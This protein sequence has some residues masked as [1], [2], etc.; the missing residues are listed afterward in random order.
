MFETFNAIGQENLTAPDVVLGIVSFF[1]VSI[2]GIIIGLIYGVLTAFFTKYT[3]RVRVIEPIF[4][5]V[6]SY[7]SYLTAEMF[8]FSPILS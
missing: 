4:V 3:I 6:M 2:G 7:L 1:V 8:L 5:F